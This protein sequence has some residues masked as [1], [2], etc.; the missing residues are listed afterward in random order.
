MDR[1][2]VPAAPRRRARPPRVIVRAMP[3]PA[4]CFVVLL[5]GACGRDDDTTN[6]PDTTD[7]TGP[8]APTTTA[9]TADV[10]DNLL[11]CPAPSPCGVVL[12]NAGDPGVPPATGYTAAQTCALERLAA[13]GPLRLHYSDGCAGMCYGALILVRGDASVIVEPYVAVLDG[14]I[15]LD[16]IKAELSPLADSQLCALREPAYFAACLAAFDNACTARANWFDGC[17]APA[18]AACE[19]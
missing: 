19:P 12:A 14:G 4:A 3:R 11:H 9:A 18:P 10:P 7:T 2:L 6:T 13:A 1:P 5:L 17:A 8:T 16:G 15:D